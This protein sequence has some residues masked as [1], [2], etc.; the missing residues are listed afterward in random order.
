MKKLGISLLAA[1]LAASL[2]LAGC[3]AS[4][5]AASSD[6]A[7]SVPAASEAA[8]STSE[9]A[10]SSAPAASETDSASATVQEL[11]PDYTDPA[12]WAYLETEETGAADVF[13]ICPTVYGGD[14]AA[15]AMPLDDQGS[16]ESFVGATNM[17]KGIYDGDTRFF[18]PYYR[19]VGLWVYTLPEAEREPYLEAAYADV[20][21]AFETYLADYNQ[22]QPL[23]LAGFS[24]GADLCLWLMEDYFA[25]QQL[26][27]QLV[28]CYAIGWRV[29]QE[30]LDQYPHLRL[31]QGADDTG[32][33]VTFNTEDPSVT[34][35]LTVPEGTKTFAINPL[36]WATDETPADKSLNLGAC[37]T[38]YGGEID[39]EIPQFTGAYLDPERGTLK[40]TDVDPADYPPSLDLF[41]EGVYHLY[42]YQFFYRNLE[43]NVQARLAAYLAQTQ[44]AAA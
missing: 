29:T 32:V 19:Q 39:Q 44:Q 43:E 4:Q 21:E 33:I 6:A 24:Q 7:S 42:D 12:N 2:S 34:G 16:K 1:L 5:E 18:A 31:A 10:A 26:A 11:L 37:F 20:R 25:D 3:Q 17:E 23:I 36:N 30:D 22:G 15:P 41:E 28:A 38:N 8:A 13:F 35:S 14:E 40:V 9:P 27:D